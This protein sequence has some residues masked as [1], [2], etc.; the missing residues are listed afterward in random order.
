VTRQLLIGRAARADVLSA[1]RWYFEQSPS[2]A[3][4][5]RAALDAA[6]SGVLYHPIQHP[7][8]QGDI[9]AVRLSRFTL[10][11]FVHCAS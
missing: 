4:S 6:L 1:V 8:V 5:F 2:L 3:R 11:R 10:S 7:R 9:R